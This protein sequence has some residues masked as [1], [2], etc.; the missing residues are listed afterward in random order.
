MVKLDVLRLINI[1]SLYGQVDLVKKEYGLDLK[2][3]DIPLDDENAWDLIDSCDTMGIFQMEGAIGKN[4]I[5]QINPRNIEELSAVNAF[6]RPGTS[7]LESYCE[8]KKDL[9]K[10]T[11]YHPKFDKWLEPTY[12]AI[13]YQE[14]LLGLISE[15]MGIS[16]GKA[17]IYRRALEKPN[18]K[19][20]KELVDDFVQN[21]VQRGIE[22]EAGERIQKAI[23]DN[24]G[25]LFNKSH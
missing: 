19:G 15:M 8:V 6:V 3:S 1:E 21:G 24:A 13:I 10:I 23:I 7:G 22:K 4:I 11:K 17:D 18:K 25:Y 20:N 14:Q 12:G 16:F 9:S 2:L 5:K